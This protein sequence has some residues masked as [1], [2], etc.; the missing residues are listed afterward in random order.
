MFCGVKA[1]SYVGEFAHVLARCDVNLYAHSRFISCLSFNCNTHG[2]L[3]AGELE[4]GNVQHSSRGVV[5]T[6]ED[7]D[8][9]AVIAP[10]LNCL[11]VVPLHEQS[12]TEQ[13]PLVDMQIVTFPP[14]KPLHQDRQA[15]II[16]ADSKDLSYT[17]L[18]R[19]SVSVRI[20]F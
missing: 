12:H 20:S 18:W 4:Q 19:L 11:R 14:A 13:V 3:S 16:I 6:H 2:E 8:G 17:S 15:R 5:G 10:S 7:T 9:G 1:F